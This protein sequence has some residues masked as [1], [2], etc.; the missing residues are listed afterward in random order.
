MVHSLDTHGLFRCCPQT[1]Y[2][3]G[4]L[5]TNV[6]ISLLSKSWT[7][8][9]RKISFIDSLF[10]CHYNSKYNKV[11]TM[12]WITINTNDE[13][14]KLQTNILY[15]VHNYFHKYSSRCSGIFFIGLRY[16]GEGER[17]WESSLR[18][19]ASITLDSQC[20]LTSPSAWQVL[21][22]KLFYCHSNW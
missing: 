15:S 5:D 14:M 9:I 6:R 11:L 2:P 3:G 21:W 19:H 16:T 22:M 13:I 4:R 17:F 8:A 18:L 1:L 7:W 10:S 20:W 12:Y